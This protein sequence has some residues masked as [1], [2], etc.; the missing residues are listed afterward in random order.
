[1][2]VLTESGIAL[3]DL[4]HPTAAPQWHPLPWSDTFVYLADGR[5]V[6]EENL[7]GK[8][9]LVLWDPGTDASARLV[10]PA[11]FDGVRLV[12]ASPAGQQVAAKIWNLADPYTT[13][14]LAVWDRTRPAQPPRTRANG[15]GDQYGKY[16]ALT[17]DGA[18]L[19]VEKQYRHEILVYT[20]V[21][22]DTPPV[23]LA[24][25]D[26]IYALAFSPDGRWLAVGTSE[27]GV[28][29]WDAGEWAAK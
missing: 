15:E 28:R 6:L 17:V 24:I 8:Q 11:A 5:L 13:D 9:G 18:W 21:A 7:Q 29:V 4:P 16:A 1:M 3:I 25:G 23:E 12:G 2:G 20:T 27:H 22:L 19:A 26:Y 10:M 14:T